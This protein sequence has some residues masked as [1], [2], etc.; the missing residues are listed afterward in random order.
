MIKIRDLAFEYFDRDEEGNLTEMIQ[1]IRGIPFDAKKGD[2]IAVA[3]KNGSG[4]S[5]FAKILNRLLVPVEGTV[6]IGGRDAMDE[7][8]AMEIR[9]MVGMVF[10]SPDDQLIGS[11]VAEDV[12]FGAEN[13]GVPQHRLWER[14]LN[15]IAQA[16]LAVYEPKASREEKKQSL[17]QT[18][19]RRINE[20]SGGE[21]Q[22]TA[23]AGVLAMQP[24]CI[25][26]DEA[27]SMLDPTSRWEILHLM[28]RLNE[29]AKITIILITHKME[30]LL[31]A[32]TIY[33][34]H[35]GK[36][37]LK[38]R[39]E[40]IFAQRDKLEQLG[41]ECPE[42]VQIK[43]WLYEKKL[44][45]DQFVFS[46]ND[47][48]ARLK[49]EHPYAF[50]KDVTMTKGTLEKPKVNPV[51]AI[52]INNLSFSYGKREILH[53][54]NL[55]VGKG[56]YV[57]IVGATGAGKSTLI[58][59]IPGLLKAKKEM[60]YVDGMDVADRATDI[61]KLR[62]KIGYVFQYPEQ[63]LFAKNVYEDVV[64]GP[65]NVGVSEVEAEK[66]AYEAI[67]LVG[68]PEE[69]YDIPIQKLSGG[70]KRRVALAGVL[71]MKPEYL[72]LDE[73]LAGLD[74]ESKRNML[75]IIDKLHKEAGITILMVSHDIESVATY[76]ERVIVMDKGTVKYDGK[77]EQVF[78][79]LAMGSFAMGESEQTKFEDSMPT[80]PAIM[81][82]L[83]K[84]RCA[85]LP[86]ECRTIK[87]EQGIKE[88]EKA[89][90]I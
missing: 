20:L 82:L 11:V 4:K 42:I 6:L 50:L 26:L 70:Q 61:R 46:V 45:R 60:V 12:A 31:L 76:A 29:E 33:I 27:T 40:G 34:L 84:L 58:Q 8:N 54:V 30:E 81:E 59:H 55:S 90:K 77:P 14:V 19:N 64:F 73:P 66:R 56:E 18:A 44:L 23:I 63:Q 22:K 25:V 57:A 89:L 35:K 39:K 80:V 71:A 17:L 2:F 86:V 67:S 51:N 47:L 5:T 32:D 24:D 13:I 87:L 88:I 9:K 21:K 72:I 36:L 28:K 48:V 37:A 78:Y 79:E 83:V 49:K 41:L 10:Q 1:A 85:G 75:E 38:G 68:L 74:P 69:I 15:A 52:L 16:G 3:G 53:D 43:E 7:E 65:R 62:T